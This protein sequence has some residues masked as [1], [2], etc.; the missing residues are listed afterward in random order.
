MFL[1]HLKCKKRICL[2]AL[3]LFVLT[4]DFSSDFS[5][6][7]YAGDELVAG[8]DFINNPLAL[9]EKEMVWLRAHPELVAGHGA[10]WPPYS[11]KD[12]SGKIIGVCI[13][14]TKLLAE[15]MGVKIKDHPNTLWKDVYSMAQKHEL[16]IV[17]AMTKRPEREEW[18]TFPDTYLNLPIYLVTRK[19]YT[20]IKK[21]SDVKGK[22]IALIKGYWNSKAMIKDYPSIK[23][24]YKDTQAEALMAV[25]DG[26]ADATMA[27]MGVGHYLIAKSGFYNLKM[28][29]PFEDYSD[30]I[31]VSVRKDWPELVSIIN[32][33]NAAIPESVR[34]QLFTKW[35][36]QL[37]DEAKV[38]LLSPRQ[39]KW[40]KNHAEISLGINPGAIPFEFL[41]ET[42]SHSGMSSE[43][44]KLIE[45]AMDVKVSVFKTE[46]WGGTIQAINN[47][48]ADILSAVVKTDD[49]QVSLNFTRPYL[50]F[51]T[52]IVMKK[53]SPSIV[54]IEDLRGQNVG[55]I[56]GYMI[57]R[58][59]NKNHTGV[60]LW[61][62]EDLESA[63]AGVE[64]GEVAGFVDSHAAVGYAAKK[65]GFEKLQ[66]AASTPYQ[67]ELCFAVRKDWPELAKM[68]DQY[69]EAMP[70]EDKRQI[71]KSWLN[72]QITQNFDW[73]N[74]LWVITGV[75]VILGGIIS[76]FVYW[77]RKLSGEILE[78]KK[79]EVESKA[80]QEAAELANHAK[81]DFLANMSHEIRTPMNAV[82]GFSELLGRMDLDEKA[83]DYVDH[84]YTSGSSLLN[85]INDIL[86]LSKVESGKFELQHS[87]VS[88]KVL[89]EEMRSV[90]SQKID[91][92]GLELK[93]EIESNVPEYLVL[94]KTR[95]RQVLVNFIGNALKF[96]AKG[97]VKIYADCQKE[98]S[99]G[100]SVD[101]RICI[102]DTGMGIP[103]DQQEKVFGAFEQI[104]GQNVEKFGGTGLGLAISMGLIELMNGK[105]E[106]DSEVGRGSIFTF[107]LPHIEIT[108]KNEVKCETE[109]DLQCLNFAPAKILLVDDIDYN[110]EL[111]RGYMEDYDF[112]IREAVNGAEALD[113]AAEFSPHLILLDMKMPVMDGYEV[114]RKL[115]IDSSLKNIPVIAV[116]ASALIEDEEFINKI[117]NGYLRKPVNRADLLNVLAEHLSHYISDKPIERKAN[118]VNNKEIKL[119]AD[120]TSGSS[121]QEE[122]GLENMLILAAED[123]HLNQTLLNAQLK[124]IGELVVVENGLLMVEEAGKRQFD[125]ILAD[126]NMPECCGM[127]ATKQIRGGDGPNRD[128]PILLLSAEITP[129]ITRDCLAAGMNAV[130]SKPINRE[131]CREAILRYVKDKRAAG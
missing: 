100:S 41:D 118:K 94:D 111:M 83:K 7:S 62:Y 27:T 48:Q 72:I 103:K 50:K 93:I 69:I 82:L 92:K 4:G 63:F 39:K 131:A 58:W 71:E 90:F 56:K 57:D 42:G 79:A 16:D 121:E 114:A 15:K 29:I 65:F 98:S 104:A 80:A 116:T 25:S 130:L 112:E 105:I 30:D 51:P 17:S 23:Y 53:D 26:S 70:E 127:E 59:I 14:Y 102:E 86:D 64:S 9:T 13:D 1:K 10:G 21:S 122:G 43:F 78:R 60:K 11:Y 115:E 91:D 34:L 85:L 77:N 54:G 68:I 99:R 40:L 129:E 76:M 87:A 84:I 74:F 125:C 124:E 35:I 117:C 31:S 89:F 20:E 123:C 38:F 88:L 47:R 55:V 66:I 61:Y 18:F 8:Y 45:Q 24:I 49:Q 75:V 96:T 19:D 12:S 97:Y 108:T 110:R 67:V 128:T 6:V 81:S 113:I 22:T 32:K 52:V 107:S 37:A 46:D 5:R 33:A 44:V 126:M 95:I 2:I 28:A 36:P 3:L 119:V 109:Y 106:I 120:E 101:L 73:Q